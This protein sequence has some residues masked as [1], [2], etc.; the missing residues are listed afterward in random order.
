MFPVVDLQI[1]WLLNWWK[2]SHKGQTIMENPGE[3]QAKNVEKRTEKLWRIYK[4]EIDREN[5]SKNQEKK[6][7]KNREKSVRKKFQKW[8]KIYKNWGKIRAQNLVEN[9]E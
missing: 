8:R 7:A 3:K 1:F 5:N 2:M 6:L 9:G 4:K